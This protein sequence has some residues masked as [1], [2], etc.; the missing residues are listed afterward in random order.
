MFQLSDYLPILGMFVVAVGFAASQIIL[1]QLFGPK[2]KTPTKLMPYEC[3]KDPVGS[4]REG[5]SV[6]FYNV[7]VRLF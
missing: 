5:F 2:K 7:A 1:T 4:A 6:K 3:G